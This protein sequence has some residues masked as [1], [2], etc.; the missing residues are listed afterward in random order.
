[1]WAGHLAL[2]STGKPGVTALV[3]T[4]GSRAAAA[5]RSLRGVE[6]GIR[7]GQTELLA[8]GSTKGI[9]H[10]TRKAAVMAWVVLW[11]ALFLLCTDLHY[12]QRVGKTT[13]YLILFHILLSGG[14]ELKL[15]RG[16]RACGADAV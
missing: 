16:A 3:L 8:N 6:R 9:R 2:L 11:L 7:A 15:H 4:V 5:F 1:M 14:H 10:N 12:L 13:N